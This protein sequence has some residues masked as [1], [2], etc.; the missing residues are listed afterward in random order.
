M[1]KPQN[2]L[3]LFAAFALALTG[4]HTGACQQL[5][6]LNPKEVDLDY[7]GK[8]IKAYECWDRL[9]VHVYVASRLQTG[10]F[11]DSSFRS[12]LHFYKA[13]NDHGGLISR[14]EARDI[15]EGLVEASFR[16]FLV[17]D[18]D[19]DGISEAFIS[20][21]LNGD[22]L[23]PDTRKVLVYYKDKK[24]AI[25][26]RVAKQDGDQTTRSTDLDFETLPVSVRKLALQMWDGL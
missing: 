23:D 4:A 18:V 10:K 2:F 7:T 14:W 3:H 6:V 24:Y 1:P 12:E 20:Y 19:G 25:R 16:Q 11:G 26:G 9:G 15:G 17:K 21:E 5:T 8:L 13:T 22:G